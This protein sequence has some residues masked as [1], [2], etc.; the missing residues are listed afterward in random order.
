MKLFAHVRQARPEPLC[1]P[2]SQDGV[3]RHRV[4]FNLLPRTL[5]TRDKGTSVFSKDVTANDAHRI[6]Q[7]YSTGVS[8]W[9][10]LLNKY[11]RN[12]FPP[13]PD[14]SLRLVI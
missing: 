14:R 6:R 8:S 10:E 1:C 7:L 2:G 13:T 4:G 11:T 3:Q 12:Y 9:I 5:L